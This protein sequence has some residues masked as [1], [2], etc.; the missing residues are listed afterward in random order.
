[1]SGAC[2]FPG[3]DGLKRLM[4][5]DLILSVSEQFDVFDSNLRAGMKINNERIRAWGRGGFDSCDVREKYFRLE[6]IFLIL[7]FYNGL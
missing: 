4:L 6:I 5:R 2:V 1:M 3:I 7:T